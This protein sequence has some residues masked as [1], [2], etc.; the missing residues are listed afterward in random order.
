[1]REFRKSALPRYTTVDG[2]IDPD[3]L[4]KLKV[5][6]AFTVVKVNRPDAIQEVPRSEG[7]LLAL[8]TAIPDARDDLNEMTAVPGEHRGVSDAET[9]TQASIIDINARVRESA[10]REKVA[11]FL[12]KVIKLLLLIS[13]EK[14]ALPQWIQLHV[15]PAGLSPMEEILRV[16]N[17]WA[18]IK[19]DAFDSLEWDVTVDVEALSPATEDLRRNQ[20]LNFI[21]VMGTPGALPV[22]ASETLLKKTAAFFGIRS[23]REITEIRQS[24]LQAMAVQMQMQMQPGSGGSAIPTPEPGPV[25]TQEQTRDQMT[26]Q[27][28]GIQ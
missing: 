10:D 27:G 7:R 12:A 11:K 6:G 18:Q 22:L 15:D 13:R 4:E 25:P 2:A 3:E 16:A 9:A 8:K 1:M 24:V 19:L 23:A 20:W 17:G 26:A 14:M 21:G 28:V 5:G